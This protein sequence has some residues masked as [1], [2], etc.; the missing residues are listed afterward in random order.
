MMPPPNNT[1]RVSHASVWMFE[2]PDAR[3]QITTQ[4]LFGEHV[5]VLKT[6]DTWAYARAQRDGYEGW[7]AQSALTHTIAGDAPTHH[8]TAPSA[9][10]YSAPDFHGA[11]L[12]SLP[13]N[14]AIVAQQ[15]DDP[16]A[17]FV[18]LKTSGFI[19]VQQV[20]PIVGMGARDPVA[21]A[22]L[23]LGTPYA[24]GGR[25]FD[26]IDCSGLVQQ[27]LWACGLP[28][29][30]DSGDQWASLGRV[31]AADE[32][33]LQGDLVFFPGHVGFYLEGGKL[34]HANATHMRCTIDP[35]EDVISW[36]SKDHDAPLT[37][38]KRVP[39]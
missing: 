31:L 33:P 11:P 32:T 20:A 13:M 7:V 6:S 3:S 14:A 38:F 5:M 37:G 12:F 22:K 19:P 35:L 29:A 8:I 21:I 28:C 25:T 10:V 18:A 23:F 9:L 30:R 27:C 4:L 36:V 26:G 2:H 15:L 34:L 17:A 16:I 1:M 24:W 39:L